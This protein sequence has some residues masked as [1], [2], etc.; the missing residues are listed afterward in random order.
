MFCNAIISSVA[1]YYINRSASRKRQFQAQFALET[2]D[3]RSGLSSRWVSRSG[4]GLMSRILIVEDDKDIAQLIAHYLQKA[5]HTVEMLASGTTA[6]A[7]AKAAAPDLVVLDL[8]LPGMDG[9]LVCQTLRADPATALVPII[10][11]TARAEESERIAGLELGADDYV[12]KPFSPGELMARVAAL[13]RRV[14]RKPAGASGTV[15]TYGPLRL[16]P[17]R[18]AV[19]LDGTEVTL[20]AKEFLLLQYFLEH[21]GRVL[22]RDLL[23]TDVWGYQ[24]TGGT[25]TVDVHVRRLREKLPFLTDAIV[26]IKQFGYKLDSPP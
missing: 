2:V 17:E 24:Y 18:H 26:T 5:G 16:D 23:L 8:M 4:S 3:L 1:T 22:S 21:R 19:E 9:L 13:L 14:Q 10:M 20:T 15:M 6:V 11:L 7:R 12:T 25:R